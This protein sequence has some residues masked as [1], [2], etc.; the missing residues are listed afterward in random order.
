MSRLSR[1]EKEILEGTANA[2]FKNDARWIDT[3]QALGSVK[4]GNTIHEKAVKSWL[5]SWGKEN[6][7][8]L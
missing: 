6:E 4:K 1:E 8:G 2:T 3:Q 5:E 7:K